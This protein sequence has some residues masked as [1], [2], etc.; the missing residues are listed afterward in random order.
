MHPVEGRTGG[1]V[2][3][4]DTVRWEGLQLGFANYHVSLI[5]PET[6]RSTVLL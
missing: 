3:A 4:G 6:W 2:T 1:L 5:V